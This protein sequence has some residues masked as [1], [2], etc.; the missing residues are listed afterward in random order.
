M[1]GAG[2]AWHILLVQGQGH[3]VGF[4]V[5]LG[6]VVTGH[7]LHFRELADH[8]TGQVAFAQQ[9]GAGCA[10]GVA[11]DARGDKAGQGRDA[12]RLVEHRAQLRLEH[13]IG[14]ALVEAFQAV[15]LVLLE[16]ELGVGQAWTHDFLVAGNDLRRVFAFYVGHGDKARQQFAVAIEQ[17]EVLLVVLHGG[18][19][20]FLRHFEEAFL[21]RTHQRHRPFHQR[22]DF[23]QQISRHDGGALL[24]GG[25]FGDTGADQR[26]AFIQVG[27]HIGAAQVFQV[28]RRLGNAHLIRVMEAVATGQTPGLL[29]EDFAVDHLVT[30][31]HY[32]PLGWADEFGLAC[33][34][35]H[36]LGNRQLVQRGLDDAWQQAG[37]GLAGNV[38]AEFQLRAA[39]VNLRQVDAALLG[40]TQ[41]GLGRLAFGIEGG[42]HGRAVEVDAAIR[43]LAGQLLNQHGQTPRC[44]IDACAAVA[45]ASGFQA[46]LDAAEE[47][48]AEVFQGFRWQLFGAQLNQEIVR[49]HSAASSF[50]NTSSRRSAGAIGK[51]SLARACR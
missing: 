12:L 13:H 10:G 8:F 42:L 39:G 44:G 30:K 22:A 40:E 14:Q 9:A 31:Q 51:P 46:L 26:A 28:G 11:A 37:G 43:L 18:D 25:Q 33:A 34:P 17:A 5:V 32:Q 6:V 20:R 35:A 48:L 3:V 23:I 19:Q 49:T 1:V 21:E 36:A 16:E 24:L 41:G 38:L 45:Q 4:A 29:G 2:T 50:A 15:L 27:Q 47:G 7:A